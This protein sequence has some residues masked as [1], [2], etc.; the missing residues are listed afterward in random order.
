MPSISDTAY[1]RLKITPSAKELEEIYTP[2]LNELSF[3][4]ERTRRVHHRAYLLVLLKT[5][6]RLGYFAIFSEIPWLIIDHITKCVGLTN[7]SEQLIVYDTTTARER[8]K[9]LIR[10]FVGVNPFGKEAR[11]VIINTCTKAS[12]TRDDLPDIINIA[13]EELIKQRYELPA[14]SALLRLARSARSKVNSGYYDL[15]Y[16]SMDASVKK[17]LLNVLKLPEGES[18]S[19]F[20]K[21]K[22]EPGRLTV[23]EFKDSL[24]HLKWLQDKNIAINAFSNT[25]ELKIRQFAAEARS[26]D[27]SSLNDIPERKRFVLVA[28]LILKQVARSLDDVTN[29]FIRQIKKIHNKADGAL[30]DYRAFHSDKTDA[31]ISTLL[32]HLKVMAPENSD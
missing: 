8:H 12:G 22:N 29:M 15:I 7:V 11:Q 2:I 27:L 26:L 17:S 30:A 23:P 31:L 4:E 9:A 10:K 18:R 25:P 32:R 5:F 6:Q 13:I 28:A 1:P 21:I 19:P 16:G 14:F 20:D 24:D 3:A